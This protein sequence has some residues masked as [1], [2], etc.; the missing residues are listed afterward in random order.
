M[1]TYASAKRSL[2]EIQDRVLKVVASYDKVTAD[3]V[4]KAFGERTNLLFFFC[5]VLVFGSLE[6]FRMAITICAKLF[7][8]AATYS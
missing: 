1:R 6:Q 7:C 2:E 4:I 3:K 8:K 5:F